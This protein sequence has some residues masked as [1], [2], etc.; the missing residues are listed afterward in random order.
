M[1]SDQHALLYLSRLLVKLDFVR[2]FSVR[3]VRTVICLVVSVVCWY[4]IEIIVLSV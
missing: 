3:S 1:S 2:V 4:M